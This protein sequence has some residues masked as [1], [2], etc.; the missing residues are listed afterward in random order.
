MN[1]EHLPFNWFD[2]LV[3]IALVLG[4]HQGR[5]HGASVELIGMFKWV[6]I[7]LG[8]AFLYQPLGGQLAQVTG[9][10]QLFGYLLAYAGAGVIIASIFLFLKRKLADRL[11]GSDAFGR[12][13]FYLGMFAGIVRFA[14]VLIAGMALLNARLYSSAEVRADLKFQNDVYGSNFFPTLQSV[15]AQVF[16]QS[17]TGSWIKKQLAVLLIKPTA[18][19]QS[20]PKQPGK[21]KMPEFA[22]P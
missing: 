21:S 17:V 3:V 4:Y 19:D 15:Q 5:K 10:G 7:L 13:E 2:L 11:I 8:C 14:C 20:Q 1:L 9:L 16:E 22:M 18:P 12:S 6:A